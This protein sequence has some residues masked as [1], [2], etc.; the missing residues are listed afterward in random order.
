MSRTFVG[1]IA[2]LFTGIAICSLLPDAGELDGWSLLPPLLAISIAIATGRLVLGLLTAIVAAATI[3]IPSSYGWTLPLV[4]IERAAVDFIWTPLYDSFQLYILAF[5]A[6][7]VG[8][9]RV[10]ALAGGTHGIAELLARRA[11]GASSAKLASFLMG[12]AIFFD[13]YANTLVVGTT[14][15]PVA[16]KF[17]V[18]REKLAYIVDS[19]AAPVAGI[20]VISTW[21][22]YEVGLFEEVMEDL[23]TGVSGYELFFKALPSRFYCF[24]SLILVGCTVWMNR[25]YGPMLAA[26]RRATHTGQVSRPGSNPM[27]GNENSSLESPP[28]VK[29]HWAIA[30]L[31]VGVVIFGVLT[32]MQI[33]AVIKV[34]D[35]IGSKGAQSSSILCLWNS[36]DVLASRYEFYLVNTDYWIAVFS[37][38]DGAK[39]MFLSAL[40]GTSV[41]WVLAKSRRSSEGKCLL[42]DSLIA[43]TWISGITNFR[44]ALIILVLAWAIKEACN[45]V[46]TGSYLISALGSSLP[47]GLVPVI[48]FLLASLVAFSIGTSWTTMAILLPS[49]VPLAYELGGMPI[50]VL[51]S[52][53]VL[54]GAIFG[55][56]CSPISDTTVL[57]SIAAAC[58]HIDHV[59]TQI[60][61]AVTAMTVAA[62]L[63]YV[64]SAYD[65]Y[66]PLVGLFAGGICIAVFVRFMGKNPESTNST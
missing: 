2:A 11:Q 17:R 64:G 6:C 54:D 56:H 28:G 57:S 40:C 48:V 63:G 1:Y 66:S 43:K 53:A 60:P 24:L 33:D 22:G 44:H 16:D 9:V 47:P 46:Q 34:G 51:T 5:T 50:A 20:A 37:K 31:P 13:D 52:A 26:E 19:T 38:A 25:D 21:I 62:L 49:M 27:T 29:P 30:A 14:M 3:S 4:V 65:L 18:S 61:Y 12:L 58:D 35:C 7:L 45:A 32:G 55:A 15:R 23:G 42:R 41:A 8:M 39:V 59:K 10:V 36:L